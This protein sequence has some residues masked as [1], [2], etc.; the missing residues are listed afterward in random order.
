MGSLK[1]PNYQNSDIFQFFF[2][3]PGVLTLNLPTLHS[4]MKITSDPQNHLSPNEPSIQLPS[5]PPSN[6]RY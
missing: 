3:V 6:S 2:V 5:L 4:P 1:S